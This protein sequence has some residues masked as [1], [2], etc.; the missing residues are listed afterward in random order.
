MID[1]LEQSFPGKKSG[2][3]IKLYA[4][5][6]WGTYAV[7]VLVSLLA[8][9]IPAIFLI[10]IML[11]RADV[12]MIYAQIITVAV[13]AYILLILAI[14]FHAFV[15]YYL[16][17][18]VVTDERIIYIRQNGFLF[19]QID[20]IHLSDIE[21]VGVD[22]KG[23]LPSFLNYGNIIIHS[24]SDVGILTVESVPRPK[25]LARKIMDLHFQHLV[26]HPTP[27][28]LGEP[29]AKRKEP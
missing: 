16:D 11:A 7:V 23:A 12:D 10:V 6:H 22:I 2:D 14:A 18:L 1:F 24:G 15:D 4:K 20:E 26:K 25:E 9:S 13:G 8:S 29:Y 3:E 19:Q 21:E 5:K 27:N 17:T 28:E